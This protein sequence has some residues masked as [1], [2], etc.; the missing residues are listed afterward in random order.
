[1]RVDLRGTILIVGDLILDRYIDGV[2]ERISPEAPVPVLLHRGEREVAG[3][4][5][6]VA[7]NV[8]K[9]GGHAR[10]IGI[11]GDDRPGERLDSILRELGIESDPV[12]DR[13]RPT[14]SKI[15]VMADKHQFLRI[16]QERTVL[17]SRQIE[18][19][20]VARVKTQL[21][22]ANALVL[23]DYAKCTLTDYILKES[24]ALARAAGVPVLV[25]PKR[26]SFAAYAGA[27]YIKPNRSELTLAT[28]ISCDD[29]E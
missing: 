17:P 22:G 24:I 4:A 12:C 1:M 16:D 26:K 6:N 29:D 27:D 7:V 3:G 21:D 19:A 14:T 18:E 20:V 25:D 23:S 9:L 2:V 13:E 5:A 15:R 11:V 8:A 28:G 10:L